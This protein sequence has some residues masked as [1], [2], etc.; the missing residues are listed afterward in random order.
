MQKKRQ[1]RRVGDVVAVDLGEGYTAFGQVLS[2]PL[3]AFYDLKSRDVPPVEEITVCPVLF[4]V[5]VMNYAVTRG[6]W[7]VIGRA[8][9]DAE[10]VEGLR[11]GKVDHY[12]DEHCVVLWDGRQE[13]A[14]LEEAEAL[15]PAAVWDPSHVVDRLND[16]YAGRPNKWLESLRSM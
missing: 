7:P 5:N 13:P 14:S 10:L 8:P 15:E 11:F 2:E 16:H 3:V 4:V 1:R 12:G 9:V 6:E